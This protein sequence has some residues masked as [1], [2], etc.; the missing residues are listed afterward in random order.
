[1]L[2]I[3]DVLKLKEEDLTKAS[4]DAIKAV[5]GI[6]KRYREME[7]IL[8]KLNNVYSLDCTCKFCGCKITKENKYLWSVCTTCVGKYVFTLKNGLESD[9]IYRRHKPRAFVCDEN[10]LECK[11]P[12]CIKN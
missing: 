5:K 6:Q 11:F 2:T 8:E 1:M 3:E 4:F 9:K 10:C 7:E 12:D